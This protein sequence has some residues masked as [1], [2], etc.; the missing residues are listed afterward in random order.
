[1]VFFTTFTHAMLCITDAWQ[2]D[3]LMQSPGDSMN[4]SQTSLQSL[5]TPYSL[6][7]KSSASTR[8]KSAYPLF[9]RHKKVAPVAEGELGTAA[10][11]SATRLKSPGT[12][13]I[14]ITIALF[15]RNFIA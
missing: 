15:Q 13:L 14:I 4:T 12:H 5:P 7:Q 9:G 1:M 3:S 2:D 11:S 10:Y 8:P 6:I